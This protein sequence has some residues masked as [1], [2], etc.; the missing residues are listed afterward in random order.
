MEILTHPS[1][2]LKQHAQEVERFSDRELKSLVTA[3][4]HAMYDAPGVGLAAT[5]VGVLRRVLVY[6]IDEGLVALCNPRIVSASE[7]TTLSEEGCL[8]LPGIEVPVERAVSVTC[9]ATDIDGGPVTIEASGLLARV[10]QHEIDHLDGML[11]IDRAT[12]EERRAA[13]RRYNE[14]AHTLG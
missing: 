10:L 3:M 5:Q 8:S 13:I 9:E 11:I 12:P 4:A 6:D 2:A 14:V 1:P 7:E